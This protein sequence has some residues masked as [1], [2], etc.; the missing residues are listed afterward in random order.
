MMNDANQNFDY[1]NIM[2]ATKHGLSE[3]H[4]LLNFFKLIK[5]S[6]EAYTLNI[7]KTLANIL[8]N[9][10]KD[11]QGNR[12]SISKAIFN[13]YKEYEV[14]NS[15]LTSLLSKIDKELIDPMELFYQHLMSVSKDYLILYKEVKK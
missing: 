4:N 14:F 13:Q 10:N 12:E 15:K 1:E 3:T 8:N 5:K 7:K 9:S 11:M 6:K 2:K